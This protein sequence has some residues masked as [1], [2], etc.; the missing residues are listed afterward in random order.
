MSRL[1]DQIDAAA[2]SLTSWIIGALGAGGIWSVRKVMFMSH[3]ISLM[4]AEARRR[5]KMLADDAARRDKQRE[6]D[7]EMVR[8]IAK[9]VDALYTRTL[10]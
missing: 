9:K 6:E 7:R 1:T 4:E 8:D 10:Q 3:K 2:Q 5:D